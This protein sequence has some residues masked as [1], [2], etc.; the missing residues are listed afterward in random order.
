MYITFDVIINAIAQILET[1]ITNY[2]KPFFS[3]VL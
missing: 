2:L 3:P 1:I